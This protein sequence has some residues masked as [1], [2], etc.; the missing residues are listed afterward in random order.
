MRAAVEAD[1]LETIG[2]HRLFGQQRRN[3]VRQLDL[4]AG[5]RPGGFEQLEDPAVEHVA[6]HDRQRARRI[7]RLGLLDHRGDAAVATFEIIRRDDAVAGSLL[8]LDILHGDQD[9][10]VIAV[11]R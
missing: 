10:A 2:M 9:V 11:K 7:G 3:G 6:T 4:A 5:A 8:A 1:A